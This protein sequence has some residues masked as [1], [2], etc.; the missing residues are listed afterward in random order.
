MGDKEGLVVAGL[1]YP[2]PLRKVAADVGPIQ[3]RLIAAERDTKT[4][5]E[6]SR[7]AHPAK[8]AP[9]SLAPPV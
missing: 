5:D 3:V 7:C 1:G 6:T 8:S 4:H 2:R 9:R